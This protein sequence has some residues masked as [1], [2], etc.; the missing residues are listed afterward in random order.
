MSSPSWVIHS[1]YV[2]L[3]DEELQYFVLNG[4]GQDTSEW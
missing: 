2:V 1:A 4:S 3:K